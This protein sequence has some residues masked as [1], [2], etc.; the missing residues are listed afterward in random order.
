MEIIV[1]PGI[2]LGTWLTPATA[3]VYAGHVVSYVNLADAQLVALGVEDGQVVS[4]ACVKRHRQRYPQRIAKR[5]HVTLETR[6]WMLETDEL[7]Y[8]ATHADYLGRAS[9][10]VT[11]LCST[12]P[13][14]WATTSNAVMAKSLMKHGFVQTGVTWA[15]RNGELSLWIRGRV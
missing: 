13:K 15:G 11:E 8:V 4:V 9:R 1:K 10:L 2:E 14:L 3:L 5:A 12:W 7:G 6:R